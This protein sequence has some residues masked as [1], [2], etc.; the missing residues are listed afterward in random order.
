MTPLFQSIS[1]A[2]N[3]ADSDA[4]DAERDI[5][6][7]IKGIEE[8]LDKLSDATRRL[9]LSRRTL[10]QLAM[11]VDKHGAEHEVPYPFEPQDQSEM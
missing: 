6:E 4:R 10:D 2:I 7:C 5:G 3:R 11:L 1:S 8:V 9:R